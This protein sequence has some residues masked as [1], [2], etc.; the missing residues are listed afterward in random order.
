MKGRNATAGLDQPTDPVS[1]VNAKDE[2]QHE[3]YQ[4]LFVNGKGP[5]GL[6][7]GTA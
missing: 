3:T 2:L 7:Q 1:P 6:D 5:C 4:T